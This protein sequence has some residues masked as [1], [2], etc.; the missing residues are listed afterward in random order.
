MLHHNWP[1]AS[2]MPRS[3]TTPPLII[4]HFYTFTVIPIVVLRNS[5]RNS[6]SSTHS[7]H[8]SF[9]CI[10]WLKDWCKDSISIGTLHFTQIKAFHNTL[11]WSTSIHSSNPST[12]RIYSNKHTKCWFLQTTIWEQTYTSTPLRTPTLAKAIPP[13]PDRSNSAWEDSADKLASTGSPSPS[14]RHARASKR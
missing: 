3:Y 11:E 13:L 1:S 12:D 5:L 9:V 10:G 2:W 7:K 6:F 8:I 4:V 14:S